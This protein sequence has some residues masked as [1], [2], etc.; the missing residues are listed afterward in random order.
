MQHG[1]RHQCRPTTIYTLVASRAAAMSADRKRSLPHDSKA[2]GRPKRLRMDSWHGHLLAF[3]KFMQKMGD[4]AGPTAYNQDWLRNKNHACNISVDTNASGKHWE[5]TF[6]HDLGGEVGLSISLMADRVVFSLSDFYYGA[7]R[8]A[9]A[10]PPQRKYM[11][12]SEVIANGLGLAHV[13]AT[14]HGKSKIEFEVE[15]RAAVQRDAPHGLL[16][17]HVLWVLGDA[18]KLSIYDLHIDLPG[19]T[20][21]DAQVDVVDTDYA[22]VEL[23]P[24]EAAG[25]YRES[26]REAALALVYD[27]TQRKLTALQKNTYVQRL[28]KAWAT[29]RSGRNP[30]LRMIE[31]QRLSVLYERDRGDPGDL[32]DIEFVTHGDTKRYQDAWLRLRF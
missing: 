3:Y 32:D 11:S 8:Q 26:A 16:W 22:E 1:C 13:F 25:V 17:L 7:P 29:Q 9:S 30:P 2:R 19:W 21:G 6:T 14:E 10:P 24:F 15:D 27:R 31:E 20:R 18:T 12:A 5:I 4:T 23:E 28:T